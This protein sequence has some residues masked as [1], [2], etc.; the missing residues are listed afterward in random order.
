MRSDFFKLPLCDVINK[1][2]LA[3]WEKPIFSNPFVMEQGRHVCFCWMPVRQRP[4]V[5][6]NQ[7]C[8]YQSASFLLVKLWSAWY[9]TLCRHCLSL[10]FDILDIGTG[11]CLGSS[12]RTQLR[13]RDSRWDR[14][15]SGCSCFPIPAVHS[16]YEYCWADK[17]VRIFHSWYSCWWREMERS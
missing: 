15:C 13:Q 14:L 11:F 12:F 4:A 8:R 17:P 6:G 1:R 3:L 2:L 10:A 9:F 7:N 16:S 5:P